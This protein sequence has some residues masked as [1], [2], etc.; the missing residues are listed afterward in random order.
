M[1]IHQALNDTYTDLENYECFGQ[2]DAAVKRILQKHPQAV[3]FNGHLY[4]TI[5]GSQVMDSSW[6]TL[7][8]VP[9]LWACGEAYVVYVYEHELYVRGRSTLF[10][11]WLPDF[12]VTVRLD[13]LPSLV[14]Q[15]GE[16]DENDYTP[17][18]WAAHHDQIVSL[19]SQVADNLN[20]RIDKYP[21]EKRHAINLLQEQLKTAMDSLIPRTQ[22]DTTLLDVLLEDCTNV[23]T[24]LYL[25]TGLNA[26]LQ[27]REQAKSLKRQIDAP[28]GGQHGSSEIPIQSEADDLRVRLH[29][30]WLALRA[31]PDPSALN[32]IE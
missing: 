8:D 7:I 31:K 26:F 13:S 24:D 29:S 14:K 15:A 17:S 3:F 4:T 28:Q 21:V 23:N 30:S 1:T 27:T 18:T 5:A 19:A 10:G 9:S 2:Q 32:A 12:D 20:L 25:E 6:G 16:L 11:Q 22:I